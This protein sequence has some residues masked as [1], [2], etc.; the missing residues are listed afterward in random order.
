MELL[1]QEGIV[2]DVVVEHPGWGETLFVNDVWPRAK[3]IIHAEYYYRAEGTDVGF[4]PE[5][6]R[7]DLGARE[8]VRAKNAALLPALTDADWAV[9]PTNWQ[10]SRFPAELKCKIAILHEGIDTDL[11]APNPAAEVTLGTR[12]FRPGDEVITFVNRNLEPYRGYHVFMRALPEI[13][14][15]R[16]NAQAVIVCGDG[17]SYGEKPARGTWKEIFLADV[18]DRL[19]LECVHFVGKVPYAGFIALVQVSA[20]HVYLTYPF[21]LSW[22]MLEA[23]SAGALVVGSRTAPVEEVIDDGENGTLVDFLDREA[24]AREVVAALSDPEL[25]RGMRAAGR[26]TIVERY[27]LRR[28][29]LPQWMRF[30]PRLAEKLSLPA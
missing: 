23:M 7:H 21:V 11:V 28:R 24:L 8:R 6:R 19:P 1:R 9:A 13:L 25:R 20:V 29:C 3:L 27:D 12:T 4:D 2:P 10:G 18:K 17:A 15:A 5:F 30:V 16:P 26:R 22:S 14:A